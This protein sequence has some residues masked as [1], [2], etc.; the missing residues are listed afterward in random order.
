MA[1]DAPGTPGHAT[2]TDPTHKARRRL[3]TRRGPVSEE[4]S[5]GSLARRAPPAHMSLYTQSEPRTADHTSTRAHVNRPVHDLVRWCTRMHVACHPTLAL[6][7]ERDKALAPSPLSRRTPHQH[8]PRAIHTFRPPGHSLS[9]PPPPLLPP[10][11][12][13]NAKGWSRAVQTRRIRP[14]PSLPLPTLRHNIRVHRW[15][16][17]TGGTGA[18]TPLLRL[19]WPSSSSSSLP[20]STSF[21]LPA[22]TSTLALSAHSHDLSRRRHDARYLPPLSLSL[23]LSRAH[24]TRRRHRPK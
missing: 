7:S 20:H 5:R 23:S 13:H 3:R 10:R 24:T 19:H 15:H 22:D 12:P 9:T 11:P 21:G 14:D 2:L 18:H 17:L 16:S 6:H 8:A 4:R 1:T